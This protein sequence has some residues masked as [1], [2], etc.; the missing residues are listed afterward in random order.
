MRSRAVSSRTLSRTWTYTCINFTPRLNHRPINDSFLQPGSRLSYWTLRPQRTHP[1][2]G[3]VVPPSCL[4]SMWCAPFAETLLPT[5]RG[6]TRVPSRTLCVPDF[7]RRFIRTWRPQHYDSVY[8][9]QR[10]LYNRTFQTRD[11]LF[12]HPASRCSASL[13]LYRLYPK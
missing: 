2:N 3:V 12:R 6:C 5:L 7:R 10:V 1:I 4:V 11:S 9:I 8:V 13:S